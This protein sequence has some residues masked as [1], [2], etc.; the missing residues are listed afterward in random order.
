MELVNGPDSTFIQCQIYYSSEQTE[1]ISSRQEL[2][3]TSTVHFH[4]SPIVHPTCLHIDD[5][6]NRIKQ[7]LQRIILETP[8]LSHM[9]SSFQMPHLVRKHVRNKTTPPFE[10]ME[11]TKH[12]SSPL[13]PLFLIIYGYMNPSSTPPAASQELNEILTELINVFPDI[14]ESTRYFDDKVNI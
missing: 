6:P 1:S 12:L 4:V 7:D 3:A 2:S 10:V 13:Q 14:V 9:P 5:L 11:T 8:A